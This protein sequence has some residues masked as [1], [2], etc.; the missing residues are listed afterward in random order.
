[1]LEFFHFC[2][3]FYKNNNTLIL[4]VDEML[5]RIIFFLIIT[6]IVGFFSLSEVYGEPIIFDDDYLV[7]IF[8]GGLHYPTTMDF[9]E[10]DILILEKNTGKVIRIITME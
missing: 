2:K 8:V 7:E 6:A 1:M 4:F 5:K 10:D 9:I 3:S